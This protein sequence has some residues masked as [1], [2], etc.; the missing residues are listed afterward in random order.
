MCIYVCPRICACIHKHYVCTYV[1]TY[2][3]Y[4]FCFLHYTVLVSTYIATFVRAYVYTLYTLYTCMHKCAS[5]H[6]C[7]CMCMHMFVHIRICTHLYYYSV[8]I[9]IRKANKIS[10]N[11]LYIRNLRTYILYVR[12]YLANHFMFITCIC[13]TYLINFIMAYACIRP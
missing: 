2:V 8:R 7:V 12:I 11:V 3:C 10:V 13:T 4:I 5:A 6:L 9:Y 1:H